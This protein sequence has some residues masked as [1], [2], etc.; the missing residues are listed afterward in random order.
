LIRYDITE[1][2]FVYILTAIISIALG[3]L[4]TRFVET[5]S[6]QKLLKTT[7]FF[8]AIVIF[9]FYSLIQIFNFD[10]SYM[11]IMIFKDI[12]WIFAGIEFGI[13]SGII[14]NIRQNKRLFG[15]LIS[16]E[17]LAGILGGLSIGILVEIIDTSQLLVISGITMIV[18]FIL[19]LNIIS[20]FASRFEDAKIPNDIKEDDYT[21]IADLFKNKYYLL[22][23]LVSTLAF[24]V[25]YFIDYIFYF[26]VEQRFTDE[27]ELASFFGIFIAALNIVNLFSSVYLSGKILNRFGLLFALSI[28]PL[29]AI[30]GTSSYLL[31]TTIS[32]TFAFFVLIA[33]KLLNEAFDTSI[34]TPAYK[35]IYQS[36]PSIHRNK[37]LTFRESIVEPVAMGLAGI[38]LYFISE[39]SQSYIVYFIIITFAIIWLLL[40]KFL[41][42]NYILSLKNMLHKRQIFKDIHLLSDI[43]IQVLLNKLKS[44]DEMDVIYALD[45]L[46]KVDH[47]NIDEELKQLLKS[48]S[49][50]VRKKVIE[51]I[52]LLELD[53]FLDDL[54]LLLKTEKNKDILS[55]LIYNYCKFYKEKAIDKVKPFLDSNESLIRNS[56]IVSLVK[57][58]SL[59]GVLVASRV[60]NKLLNNE[61]DKNRL[62]ILEIINI[63]GFS[64]FYDI[65]NDSLEDGSKTIKKETIKTIGNLKIELFVPKLLAFLEDNKYKSVALQALRKFDDT[66]IDQLIGEFYKTKLHD[67][68]LSLLKIIS[69]IHTEQS[70]SFMFEQIQYPIY[71][72]KILDA[73]YNASFKA[74]KKDQ[75]LSI[76]N[77]IIDDI[78][79][80]TLQI[81]NFDKDRYKKSYNLLLE[82]RKK[83]L[84]GIFKTLSFIY[85]KDIINQAKVNYFSS[86]RNFKALSIELL[87][88]LIENKIKEKIISILENIDNDKKMLTLID[89]EKYKKY[90]KSEKHFIKSII[91][92]PFSH[93][94]VRLSLIYEIANNKEKKYYKSICESIKKEKNHYVLETL[95]YAKKTIEIKES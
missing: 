30:V 27:K 10:F 82:Q 48:K 28:I 77:S 91:E 88:N 26:K 64:G 76:T 5:F 63:A 34:L 12:L 66:I 80:L 84:E 69:Y 74:R 54:D 41:K 20:K 57:Y 71:K 39:F 56:T 61:S 86:S 40:S 83:E 1:L 4:Y 33:V 51:L 95:K 16:G 14:F 62:E 90:K 46:E 65:L 67:K 36:I 68:K 53:H 37:I 42:D 15:L 24:F 9:S 18:S 85:Q 93:L 29:I 32:I 31:L 8:L 6:V 87:D 72:Y 45:F 94:I 23:F 22:F 38:L 2:P 17:I 89:R 52:G 11:G 73:L 59:E 81:R 50:I 60:I 75:V 49:D 3:L 13:I 47:L 55:I 58:C 43:D 35:V 19:L 92:D 44:K 7:M 78:L 79:T 21:S 25:F 70:I